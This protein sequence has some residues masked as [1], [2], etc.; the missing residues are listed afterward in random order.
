MPS[1]ESRIANKMS[2]LNYDGACAALTGDAS[3]E[4]PPPVRTASLARPTTPGRAGSGPREV[5]ADYDAIGHVLLAVLR[6]VHSGI[7]CRCGLPQRPS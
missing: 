3:E 1:I 4:E 7:A 5:C 6:Q 2:V